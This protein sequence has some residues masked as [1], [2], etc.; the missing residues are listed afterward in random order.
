MHGCGAHPQRPPPAGQLAGEQDVRQL[1][2]P[3]CAPE[4]IAF[5]HVQVVH[6]DSRI[7]RGP[8]HA[9]C[10]DHPSPRAGQLVF[11]KN[12]QQER[13]QVVHLERQLMPVS[14]ENTLGASDQPGVVDQDVDPRVPDLQRGRQ[15]ANLIEMSEVGDVIVRA[16][17]SGDR[18]RL[19]GRSA[20]HHDGVSPARQGPRGGGADPVAGPSHD[21]DPALISCVAHAGTI[22]CGP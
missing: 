9:R 11:E 2:R 21:H 15:A 5:S 1:G 12:G 13:G 10:R 22:N 16:D 18:P 14:G 20:H 4:A 7:P 6:D 3:V 19:S 17:I 8:G